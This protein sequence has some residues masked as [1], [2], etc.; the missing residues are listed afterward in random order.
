[1]PEP[2]PTIPE[3]T[4][5]QRQQDIEFGNRYR[6]EYIKHLISISAGIFAFTVTFTKDMLGQQ[7]ITTA[8][9]KVALI[10]GWSLLVVSIIAGILHMRFWAWF[11]ISWGRNP[12]DPE[13]KRWRNTIMS[14]RRTAETVQFTAFFLALGSLALF[15]ALNLR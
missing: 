10:T 8:H 13:E 12:H 1:M 14:R 6:I 9:A 4:V 15:A 11:F 7:A 5:E 2:Q 3:H